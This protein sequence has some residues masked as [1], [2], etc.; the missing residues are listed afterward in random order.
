VDAS[1]TSF[2]SCA[3]S[4]SGRQRRPQ[5]LVDLLP[6][7]DELEAALVRLTEDGAQGERLVVG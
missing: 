6:L 7:G 3:W 4:L 2:A 5:L 1:S